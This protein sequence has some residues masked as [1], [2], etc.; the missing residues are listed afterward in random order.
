M[1]DLIMVALD[2]A[3]HAVAQN[4]TD[5]NMLAQNILALV[6]V[7]LARVALDMQ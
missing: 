7:V 4:M 2:M 1:V 6:M 5:L 3:L